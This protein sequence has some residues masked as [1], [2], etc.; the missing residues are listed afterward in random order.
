VPD[1]TKREQRRCSKRCG[2]QGGAIKTDRASSIAHNRRAPTTAQQGTVTISR[3]SCCELALT[4]LRPSDVPTVR[5][6]RNAREP[7]TY[8]TTTML[9]LHP[10]SAHPPTLG[11]WG[12]P[13]LSCKLR[14][15]GS[16]AVAIPPGE[17]PPR[18][19]PLRHAIRVIFAT[20][21]LY[22]GFFEN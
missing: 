15:R 13:S 9:A 7:D 10:S 5:W 21:G 1:Q 18:T 17:G 14:L 11:M 20:L 16:E 2:Y 22:L 19:P 6:A 3:T 4:I 8:R 12:K